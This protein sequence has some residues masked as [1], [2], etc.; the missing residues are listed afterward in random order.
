MTGL[1]PI[2]EGMNMGFLLLG[3]QPDSQQH[4][5]AALHQRRQLHDP[6]RWGAR[7]RGVGRQLGAEHSQRLE[8]YF[9][10][11][12]GIQNRGGGAPPPTP[13]G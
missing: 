9:T 6:P 8:A 12:P 11:V 3:L 4:G 13:K 2:V 1:R 5:D 7:P 10:A